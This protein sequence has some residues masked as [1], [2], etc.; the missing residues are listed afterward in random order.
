VGELIYG[1]SDIAIQFEDRFLAHAQL[2]IGP[3]LGRGESF[4]F[5]WVEDQ[6]VGSGRSTIWMNTSMP[7]YF[8]YVAMAPATLNRK[9]IKVLQASADSAQGLMYIPEPGST[10][11]S[12]PKTRFGD[13]Y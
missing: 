6:S 3:K 9:W 4:F 7:L 2:V 1:R 10:T 11:A 13:R 8:R 12:L 5:S